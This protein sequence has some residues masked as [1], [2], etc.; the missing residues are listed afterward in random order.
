MRRDSLGE[1]IKLTSPFGV[2]PKTC[3]AGNPRLLGALWTLV[4]C[5][6]N[7]GLS[8]I[9]WKYFASALPHQINAAPSGITRNA[10]RGFSS[11]ALT[12]DADRFFA[13]LMA[14]LQK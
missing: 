11:Q 12:I 3:G 13:A 4:T 7:D 8:R 1:T 9:D 10:R 14:R 6:F 5:I 2:C